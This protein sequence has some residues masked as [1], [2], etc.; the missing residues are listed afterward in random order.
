MLIKITAADIE[1]AQASVQQ[2][3][4][5]QD[6]LSLALQR[7]TGSRW[8]MGAGGVA[9]EQQDPYRYVVMPSIA[10]DATQG[11]FQTHDMP[12][13]E[14]LIELKPGHQKAKKHQP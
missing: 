13:S 3:K 1:A 12:S 9:L 11:F 6:P 14:F 5:Q 8:R 4:V 10:R 2:S 7:M